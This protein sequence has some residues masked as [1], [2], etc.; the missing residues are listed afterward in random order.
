MIDS[1][2][3]FVWC[4]TVERK[5]SSAFLEAIKD[6]YYTEGP[7]Q[8]FHSDNGGEFT[9]MQV[10]NF[11]RNVMNATIVHGAP[12]R[13]QAQGQIER[14]NRTLK[15]RIRKYLGVENRNWLVALKEI[16]YQY[17]T[18]KHKATKLPPF[19]LFKGFDTKK[20][21]WSTSNNFFEV[22]NVRNRYAVY[23]EQYRNEYNLR[24]R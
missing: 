2:S 8:I 13:P 5:S 9:A 3:K 4:Y 1:F 22:Q 20:T 11:I 18:S 19:I 6:L 21:N 12:Y 24:I 16:V 17:N 15:S 7:W 23:V 10:Q 14:F